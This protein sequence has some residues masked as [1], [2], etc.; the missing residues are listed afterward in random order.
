[1]SEELKAIQDIVKRHDYSYLDK[2]IGTATD[3][4]REWLA[5]RE[6]AARLEDRKAEPKTV[7]LAMLRECYS[8]REWIADSDLIDIASRYGYKV[9]G[10]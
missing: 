6:L 10:G 9:I 4:G 1:M 2:G 5:L 8:L 7:P 3:E